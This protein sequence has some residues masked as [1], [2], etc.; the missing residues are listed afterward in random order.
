[1]IWG[2]S[3]KLVALALLIVG[4]AFLVRVQGEIGNLGAH[5]N[6]RGW[7]GVGARF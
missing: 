4:S 2:Y 7:A 1:M 3:L 6:A 5:V